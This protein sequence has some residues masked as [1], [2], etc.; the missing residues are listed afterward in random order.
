MAF[1]DKTERNLKCYRFSHSTMEYG[2][3]GFFSNNM[4]IEL[5]GKITQTAM[6]LIMSCDEANRFAHKRNDYIP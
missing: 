3:P 6:R 5:P 4:Y 2:A 1:Q